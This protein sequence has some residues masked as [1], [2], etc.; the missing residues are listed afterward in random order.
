M[1]ERYDSTADTL[2]H[3]KRVNELMGQAAQELIRR[4]NVHD[5]SKLEEPEKSEFDRLTPKLKTLVYGSEEYKA[6]LAELGVALERHYKNNTH[7]PQWVQQF[8]EWKDIDNHDGYQVSN[9]GQVRA[10]DR[11]VIR[12]GQ[13][14][15]FKEG[16]ILKSYKT[17]HGYLRIQIQGKNYQVHR[18]VAS[19]FI[20]NEFS[21]P[22]VNHKNGVKHDNRHSNLEWCTASQNQLHAY[23]I[24]LR[25][26]AVKYVV[27][28][29]D[30]DIVT[31]GTEKMEAAL[32]ERGYTRAS[33]SAIWNCINGNN[34]THLDLTFEGYLIEEFG[35][36][37][38]TDGMTLFDVIE[39]FMDWKAATERM[40]TGDIY[41]SIEFNKGRFA[42]SDQLCK[43]FENTAIELTWEK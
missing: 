11:I 8:E 13:G 38:Y 7:H 3:I 39:M 40:D 35:K 21:Y 41:K 16:R 33:S 10:L 43:I 36:I 30:L 28:C 42:M 34:I 5:Q 23:D 18:L 9:F 27:K 2:L 22:E 29:V 31:D 12:E 20:I 24:G 32:K 26:P 14:D 6:S 4:G 17:P 1:E 19:S 25:K 37:S 15:F